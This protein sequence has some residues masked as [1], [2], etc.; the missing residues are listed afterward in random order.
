MVRGSK[1]K[2]KGRRG[3]YGKGERNLEEESVKGKK[4]EE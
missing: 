1:M 4:I 3:T 2:R